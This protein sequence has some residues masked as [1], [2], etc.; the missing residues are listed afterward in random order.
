MDN[1]KKKDILIFGTGE[2][3]CIYYRHFSFLGCKPKLVYR[4]L[5]SLRTKKALE[6]FGDDSIINF[7]DLNQINPEIILSC[8]NPESHL[9]TLKY[10]SNKENILCSEKPLSYSLDEI[11][12][13]VR[14]DLFVL[15]NRRYY[16][17]VN[18]VKSKI[19][20]GEVIKAIINIPEVS[21]NKYWFNVPQKIINNSVH[22]FDLCFYLFNGLENPE[23]I[24][25]E[26]LFTSIIT[27]AEHVPEIIFN[28]HFGAIENFGIRLYMF[29]GSIIV[30]EPLENA[31]VYDSFYIEEPT[32]ESNI[33]KYK[34]QFKNIFE[35]D[36]LMPY[37]K[38]GILELCQELITIE[39]NKLR[40]PNIKESLEVMQ[41]IKKIWD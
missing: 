32:L 3:A 20:N 24:K 21:S 36:I 23:Y 13:F 35:E 6:F 7:E 11:K 28:I 12:E 15:M 26:K 38:P 1:F 17:W 37:Q 25:N 34:P 14:N 30:C 18:F 2:M 31:R 5:N 8:T 29:D 39:P 10:F 27:S 9:E 40:L 22:L 19:K 41:W 4:N 33:R 16:P